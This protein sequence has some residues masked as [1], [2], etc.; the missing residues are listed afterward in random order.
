[1]SY[2]TD[3]LIVDDTPADLHLITHLLKAAGYTLRVAQTGATALK[4]VQMRSPDLV[5]LD[6]KM[7]DI[8]GYTICQHICAK[9]PLDHI[10]VIF[11]SA[12]E[13]SLNK[14][15][16]FKAGGIDYVTKPYEAEELLARI[17]LHLS[18]Q[19]LKHSI[20]KQNQDLRA[21]EERWQLLLQGTQDNIFDWTIQTGEIIAS[22]SNLL[23]YD[24]HELPQQFDTW[25]SLI[26]PD[27]RDRTLQTLNAYLNQE[28]PKHHLELR[29]R[30]KDGSYKWILSRGQATWAADGTPLRMVG[31][32]NDI[33]DR[34]QAELALKNQLRKTLL[35]QRITDRIR[36]CLDA[37]QIFQTTVSQLGITFQVNRCLIQRYT[38]EVSPSVPFVAEYLS[39][40]SISSV[41]AIKIPVEG[42][43]HLQQL[44]SQPQAI[45][46]DDV[47]AD[48]LL[49]QA[50]DL[51]RQINLQSMLAVGT[52]YQ[53]KANGVISLH[54]CDH[55]R[56]WTLEEIDLIEAVA[57]QMGIAI[58]QVH[59][60][61]QERQQRQALEQSNR[62]LQLAKRDA[63][64]ANQAKSRFL[65]NMSHELRT[66]LNAILGYAQLLVNDVTLSLQHQKY[67]QVILSSGDYLLKLVND[68]LDLARV[69]SGCITQEA[70]PCHLPSL[71]EALHSLFQ[72]T[73][74]R[75]GLSLTL[76][77]DTDL[78][79][80]IIVDSQKLRQVLI[81]LLAN[82]L[83]FTQEGGVIL[84]V[85][86]ESALLKDD[87][88]SFSEM[89][90]AFQVEDTGIGIAPEE[91]SYIFQA[92][93]QT[94]VG[95]RLSNS[96]GLGLS[97]SQHLVAALGGHLQVR[98]DVN[99][100]SIFYFT[101][102]VQT[103]EN[104]VTPDHQDTAW[105]MACLVPNQAV[106]CILIVDDQATSQQLLVDAL[107]PM[108]FNILTATTG[109]QALL[110]WQT[111]QPDLILM[112]FGLPD[113]DGGQVVQ[114]I[115]RAEQMRQ[116]P[117]TPI[118]MMSASVLESD[119]FNLATADCQAFLEKPIHLS[120]LI[121]KIAQ[122]L[123]LDLQSIPA[124]DYRSVSL[125]KLLSLTYQDLQVMPRDW[126][127]EL[128]TLATQCSSDRIDALI[129]QIPD[130]H[131]ALR[132]ALAYYN[133]NI[134]IGTIMKLARQCLDQPT[135]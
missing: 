10:P 14:V 89:F 11:I 27:D 15:K 129:G 101:L 106:Q 81:N 108:G 28:L 5:L 124:E 67:S 100:G 62:S 48:P 96:T 94:P 123:N 37:D 111:H 57:D 24:Q 133:Y 127:Q 95:R 30:C 114:Q 79:N 87:S 31:I 132:Q 73:A 44:L 34:K 70:S 55:L 71:L 21:Q 22:A 88:A 113:Q 42:N 115:R 102:P 66:P 58:A 51:C 117:Q 134:D 52:F 53:G 105:G 38:E 2:A 64:D 84:R 13:Q 77:L 130:D 92:F 90:L 18:T 56:T 85:L 45:A 25:V 40:P 75:K 76:E 120:H 6:I 131:I 82:A 23:G 29:M 65:A 47:L 26:H 83:K 60:M 116:Q 41:R 110:T 103:M 126:I 63:D 104:G 72:Q 39:D 20:Q 119:R 97:I 32:H 46:S 4:S 50:A 19:K 107:A 49:N 80:Y 8:D 36:Q 91:Q 43:P 54:Q 112:D 3:I 61:E 128:Y 99:R 35:I 1:M 74:S 16:A 135:D 86:V 118:F 9:A 125:S 122:H 109:K 17:Q 12:L 33:S 93:E 78:P 7:P 59:L 69:E 68:I 121:Q 98:S